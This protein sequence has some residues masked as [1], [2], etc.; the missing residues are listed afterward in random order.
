VA[1]D[2]RGHGERRD[3]SGARLVEGKIRGTCSDSVGERSRKSDIGL[4]RNKSGSHVLKASEGRRVKNRARK[5]PKT[6]KINKKDHG[7]PSWKMYA[8][9]SSS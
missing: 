1:W 2:G 8:Q 7:G 9:L 3:A 4:K 6:K 5:T